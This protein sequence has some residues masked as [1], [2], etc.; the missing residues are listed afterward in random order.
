[1]LSCRHN[2]LLSNDAECSCDD[3][4]AMLVFGTPNEIGSSAGRTARRERDGSSRSYGLYFSLSSAVSL[5]PDIKRSRLPRFEDKSLSDWLISLPP[6]AKHSR[7]LPTP[8]PKPTPR[9][10]SPSPKEKE[11]LTSESELRDCLIGLLVLAELASEEMLTPHGGG[12]ELWDGERAEDSFM[13]GGE[14]KGGCIRS[15]AEGGKRSS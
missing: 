10:P 11:T 15:E 13:G 9:I 12:L 7:P 1:M 14:P 5:L 6:S 4:V 2:V 8:N 3:S